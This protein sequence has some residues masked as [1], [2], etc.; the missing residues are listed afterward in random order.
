MAGSGVIRL[1]HE[2][3]LGRAGLKP[4]GAIAK[5]ALAPQPNKSPIESHTS[6]PLQLADKIENGLRFHPPPHNIQWTIKVSDFE[7]R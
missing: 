5:L 1:G 7:A 2:K 6:P 4:E 3:T